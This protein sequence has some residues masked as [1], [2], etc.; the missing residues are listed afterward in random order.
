MN[1]LTKNTTNTNPVYKI[2]NKENKDK[3]LKTCHAL[4]SKERILILELIQEKPMTIKELSLALNMP[5]SSVTLH[6]NI[7]QEANLI[8][9][10]YKPN[11]KGNIKLCSRAINSFEVIFENIDNNN[12]LRELVYEM[13][14]GNFSNVDIEPPC[15]LAGIKSGLGNYDH[16]SSFYLPEKKDAELLWFSSGH[17]TYLFPNQLNESN[18]IESLEFSLEICSE[19]YYSR[20]DWPSDITFYIN[21]IELLTWTSPGD[22]GGRRGKY[23]P[24]YWFINSTQYGI[25]KTIKI[26]LNGIYLDD[27]LVNEKINLNT[28]EIQKYPYIEFKIGV[29]ENAIHRGGINLF[30]KNFGDYP[31]AIV[32]KIY[33]QNI[34]A[35][36]E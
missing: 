17:I 20:N 29:K 33:T 10:E 7:L 2:S 15:G 32:M 19:T 3:I 26:N 30:G 1:S 31:Q 8:S 27:I 23:S 28:L 4:S 22:F 21:G 12:N 18:V 6:T 35:Y 9:I 13:P 36:K 16:V 25:L 5:I 14:I 34:K 24:E 11:K